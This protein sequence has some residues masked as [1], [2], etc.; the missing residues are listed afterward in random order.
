MKPLLLIVDDDEPIRTQLKWGVAEEYEAV[1]AEDRPTA[2]RVFRERRPPIVLLDL[3]LPPSPGSPEE[4]LALLSELLSIDPHVK[5]IIASGQSETEVAM[6]GIGGGAYDFMAKPIDIELLQLVLRRA[7]HV[8]ELERQYAALESS[9]R[10][11]SFE[12]MLGNSVE[13][14]E[15]YTSIRKVAGPDVPVLI[16]GD[17]GTG[18]EMAARAVHRLSPRGAGAF[19]AINCGAIPE[20]LLES[21]LFGHERGAFTG[22]QGQR[23]GRVEAAAG[24]TLFLDEVGELS[25]PLQV[26]L[27]RF[28]QDRCITR[29]GGRTEIPVDARVIAATNSNLKEQVASGKFRE[30]LFYRLAVVTL[31]LPPLRDRAGDAAFLASTFLRRFGAEVNRKSLR[32]DAA[33]LRAINRHSWP[34]NVRELENRVRRAVI[35]AEGRQ[36]TASDLE[37]STVDERSLTLKEARDNLDRELIGR[38]L[39]R[40]RGKISAAANELGISRPTLYEL[41]DKHGMRPSRTEKVTGTDPT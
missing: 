31:S 10:S 30:D 23:L 21:E 20:N 16:L 41:M 14:Q 28:L 4:G 25:L 38:A 9:V 17:S 36:V 34:G 13:M 26:K 5:V 24:G 35:M 32:F 33:A 27:L 6:Q 15:V 37:L 18:K 12:G 11:Q 19:V 40:N 7:N 8:A 22:A 3:G 2:L 1:M 39:Q 29:V